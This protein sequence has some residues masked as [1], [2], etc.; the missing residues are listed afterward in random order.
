MRI[1]YLD[2]IRGI[3]FILMLI[4]HIFIFLKLFTNLNINTNNTFLILI[5]LI[6]RYLFVILFGLSLY[7]SYKYKNNYEEY[8]KKY[9]KKII[10]LLISSIFITIFTYY[11][12]P[13]QFV[14]FGILHFMCLS[15]I[16]LF[17]FINNYNVLL[18]LLIILI[19]FSIYNNNYD[20]YDKTDNIFDGIL[21]LGFYKRSIDHFKLLKWLPIVIAGILLGHLSENNKLNLLQT[22]SNININTNTNKNTNIINELLTILKY[23]GSNTLILYNIHFPILYIIIYY[24]FPHS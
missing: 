24:L 8:N 4:F 18:I 3:A 2:Y 15:M 14:Y 13:E 9:L 6:A 12:L 11:I 19:F 10:L 5:G 20:I 21:G 23:I 16:L 17:Y 22:I 1:D 7:L